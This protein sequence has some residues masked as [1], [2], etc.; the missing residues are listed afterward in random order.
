VA[1]ILVIDDEAAMRFLI[2]MAFEV[3]GHEVDEA[4]NG[5][6]ALDLIEGG[7]IPDLV[8]TDYMMPVMNGAELIERIRR[9]PRTR[10]VP[11]V[12]ISASSG[13]EQ[14]SDPDLFLRK[15]FD[16]VALA[17]HAEKLL[18]RR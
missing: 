13:A 18:T 9:D 3:E 8:A 1:K 11:V 6:A 12:M 17:G 10:D 16:P 2:R 5:Q 15:P 7:R 14:R 4:A